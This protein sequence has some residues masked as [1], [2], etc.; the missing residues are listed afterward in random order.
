MCHVCH[1]KTFFRNFLKKGANVVFGTIRKSPIA[2][3]IEKCWKLHFTWHTWHISF[4]FLAPVR[5]KTVPVL[6][7]MGEE[8][9]KVDVGE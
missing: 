6:K 7:K 4:P 3:K 5:E 9:E 1:V 2:P 8:R